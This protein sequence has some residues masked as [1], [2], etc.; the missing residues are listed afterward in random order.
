M[1]TNLAELKQK[2]KHFKLFSRL[3]LAKNSHFQQFILFFKNV[4]PVHGFMG[5]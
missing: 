2:K 4:S 3:K 1:D 5:E